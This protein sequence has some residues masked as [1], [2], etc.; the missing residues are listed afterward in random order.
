MLPDRP[1]LVPTKQACWATVPSARQGSAYVAQGRH[2][3]VVV[4]TSPYI[5]Y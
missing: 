1:V 4:G 3:A 5:L 2:R